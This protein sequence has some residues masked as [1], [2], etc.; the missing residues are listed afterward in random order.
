MSL[1]KLWCYLLSLGLSF[2]VPNYWRAVYLE[3]IDFCL[4]MRIVLTL[5]SFFW[6]KFWGIF[7]LLSTADL[8][9]PKK[10]AL[11]LQ[12][13]WLVKSLNLF[14]KFHQ[15]RLAWIRD[16]FPHFC[17]KLNVPVSHFVAELEQIL[18]FL[19]FHLSVNWLV[20]CQKK[21][22]HCHQLSAEFIGLKVM[23]SSNND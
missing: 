7:H 10:E 8:L 9:L 14:L 23:F 20:C 18:L 12:F 1:A 5:F 22:R 16:K 4:F 3:L 21:E 19:S 17:L 11:L 2:E 13:D 15:S 6:T